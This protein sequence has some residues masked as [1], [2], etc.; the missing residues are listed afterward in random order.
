MHNQPSTISKF[1]LHIL[2][3]VTLLHFSV[4][5]VSAPVPMGLIG[6]LNLVGQ[7]KNST[8]QKLFSD[9]IPCLSTGTLW[10]SP[11]IIIIINHE[12]INLGANV[13]VVKSCWP[14]KR[15]LISAIFKPEIVLVQKGEISSWDMMCSCHEQRAKVLKASSV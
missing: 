2:L 11:I 5:P 12:G 6:F 3:R 4:S 14:L 15:G 13:K 7:R 1:N 10:Y 8:I 9:R